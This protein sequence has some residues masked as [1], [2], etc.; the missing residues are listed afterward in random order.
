MGL[1]KEIEVQ[2]QAAEF[3]R[4]LE[5]ELEELQK[6]QRHLG[7][8]RR[9]AVY[10]HVNADYT[11]QEKVLTSKYKWE[12]ITFKCNVLQGV[13]KLLLPHRDIYG[14]YD[15]KGMREELESLIKLAEQK[16]EFEIAE[17]ISDCLNHFLMEVTMEK[18]IVRLGGD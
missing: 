2:K 11:L 7:W 16:D 17:L 5:M 12:Q 3:I 10:D 13:L 8:A 6:T 15:I 14:L 18:G 1:G 9:N 4:T